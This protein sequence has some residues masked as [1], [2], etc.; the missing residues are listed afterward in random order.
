MNVIKLNT[1]VGRYCK[2][3]VVIFIQFTCPF[4]DV[5]ININIVSC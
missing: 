4:V 3:K 2:I 5:I 1:A